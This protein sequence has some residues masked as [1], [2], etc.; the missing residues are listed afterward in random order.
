MKLFSFNSLLRTHRTI[1]S[2]QLRRALLHHSSQASQAT[3]A[4]HTQAQQQ[5]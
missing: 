4:A 1:Q 2:P 5:P 3:Q